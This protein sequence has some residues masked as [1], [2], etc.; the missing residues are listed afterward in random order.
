MKD[1]VVLT[2]DPTLVFHEK[3]PLESSPGVTDLN[4][5]IKH[6][7]PQD[8]LPTKVARSSQESKNGDSKDLEPESKD[9]SSFED[10]D[11]FSFQAGKQNVTFLEVRTFRT[12]IVLAHRKKSYAF[13]VKN[14]DT[15]SL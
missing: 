15:Y 9:H 3:L 14:A 5:K 11:A 10:D 7:P 8:V 1:N 4:G 6:E 12:A 2:K 13:L